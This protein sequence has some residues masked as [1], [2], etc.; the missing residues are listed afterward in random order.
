MKFQSSLPRVAALLLTGLLFGGSI[1]TQAS[2]ALSTITVNSTKDLAAVSPGSGKCETT[3]EGKCT[4]RA[5]IQA[6]NALPG[7]DT[8]VLP[9]G[10]FTLTIAEPAKPA[11][12]SISALNIV[13]GDLDIV[14]SLIIQGAGANQTIIEGLRDNDAATT[15][16][17]DRIFDIAKPQD[18]GGFNVEVSITGVSINNGNA[19]ADS[20]GAI[21]NGG[22]LTLSNSIVANSKAVADMAGGG[23]DGGA[24]RNEGTATIR[25]TSFNNNTAD[26]D[27]GAILNVTGTLNLSDVT[28]NANTAKGDGGAIRNE[29]VTNISRSL[30]VGNMATLDG[31]AIQNLSGTLNVS[32]A[33]FTA[34][35][36]RNGGGIEAATRTIGGTT[37][38]NSPAPQ[39][40][41]V[42]VTLADNS[43]TPTAGANGPVGG[44]G[45]NLRNANGTLTIHNTIF[46]LSNPVADPNFPTVNNTNCSISSANSTVVSGGS[47]LESANYRTTGGLAPSCGLV[48]AAGDKLNANPLLGAL[49]DNGGPTRT[50]APQAGSLAID[51]GDN[52]NCASTDQ[53]GFYRPIDGNGDGVG[54]C[55]IGAV[56]VGSRLLNYRLYMPMISAGQ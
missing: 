10:T 51:G 33:T 52:T 17:N 18:I 36:A 44:G 32:N 30:F 54:R 7:I 26:D 27:G 28:F 56:E 4:L 43:A 13:N 35:K 21:D 12:G 42:N 38:P 25:N 5:A 40:T 23:G 34:N 29:A 45:E 55:D 49:G 41:L 46:S 31:G 24:I 22:I 48:G 2:T 37:D 39:T 50:M 53:R 16:F 1:P 20:G 8:I 11:A 15:D 3:D 9:A 6:A 19:V 14:D 47:N